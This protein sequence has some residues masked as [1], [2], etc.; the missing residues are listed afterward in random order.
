MRE[1][2]YS[3][4]ILT[5]SLVLTST[6]TSCGPLW[7]ATSNIRLIGSDSDSNGE[8]IY[9]TST[10]ERGDRIRSQGG[11]AF[12]GMM[13]ERLTCAACHGDDGR[14]GVHWM[15]MQKMDAPDIRWEILTSG[16][17]GGHNEE[18]EEDKETV[19]YDEETIKRVIAEGATSDGQRLSRDMPRW[20]LSDGDLVDL[21]QF[22]KILE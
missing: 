15:H 10:N 16:E 6:I 20:E 22:L 4:V 7:G 13:M 9:F 21:I 12:G 2:R 5:I 11:P 17:H 18:A 8:R 1:R 3:V 19:A 14:G